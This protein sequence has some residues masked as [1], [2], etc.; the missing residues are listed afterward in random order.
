MADETK[1][2]EKLLKT[3]QLVIG[4][5]RTIKSIKTGKLE[6]VFVAKNCRNDTK[7]DLRYYCEL[8]GAK[9]VELEQNNEE[10]GAICKKPFFI[11]VLSV[12]K[13]E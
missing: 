7:E 11:S 9:L 10:L 8:S 5:D 12:L 6:K 1:E 2:I 3:K 4:T 13:K